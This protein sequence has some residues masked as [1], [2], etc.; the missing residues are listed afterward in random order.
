MTLTRESKVLIGI[1]VLDL[2]STLVL[3]NHTGTI[4]GNPLM[5]FY[6]RYGVGMFVLMKVALVVLPLFIAEWSRQYRPRFVRFMLRSAIAIY[7][8]IYLVMFLA[9][10]VVGA[11]TGLATPPY[12]PHHH[13]HTAK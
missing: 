5:S 8:G 1:C 10:N 13:T 6:L 7:V 11:T 3:L 12:T 9:V 4:E 2:I